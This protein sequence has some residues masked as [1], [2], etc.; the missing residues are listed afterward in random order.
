MIQKNPFL[1]VL[2]RVQGG[3]GRGGPFLDGDSHPELGMYKRRKL[4]YTKL[5]REEITI[6]MLILKQHSS[7]LYSYTVLTECKAMV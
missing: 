6:T 1:T 7:I 2:G 3:Y 4:L 5:Q